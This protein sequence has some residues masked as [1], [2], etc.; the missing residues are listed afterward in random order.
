MRRVFTKSPGGKTSLVYKRPKPS[1]HHCA[2][3]GVILKGVTNQIPAKV[4]KV[5]KTHR[6]PE[7]PY[8]GYLCAK[9]LKDKLKQKI[10]ETIK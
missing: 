8:G 5:P 10:R 6:R 4:N 2:E 3:C 9:C 1:Q 7:R